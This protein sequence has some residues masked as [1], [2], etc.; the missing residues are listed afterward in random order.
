MEK[1]MGYLEG[2]HLYLSGPIQNDDRAVDWRTEPIKVLTEVFGIDVFDPNSDPKQQWLPE[3]RLAREARN[4]DVMADRAKLFV[5][6]DLQ[7]VQRTD[8]LVAYLPPNIPTTGTHHEIINSWGYK[9]P[10]LLVSDRKE[11]VPMWYYGFI[12][13]KYMFDGFP[14][15]YDYLHEVEAGKYIDDLRWATIYNL[16]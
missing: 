15:L 4:F 3:L 14:A 10:T 9:N 1:I 6:K 8:I 13:H 7:V 12:D 5:R 2:K 11:N 16:I